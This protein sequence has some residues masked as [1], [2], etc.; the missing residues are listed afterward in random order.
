MAHGAVGDIE[1]VWGYGA[2]RWSVDQADRYLDELADA[3][4][5]IA[6][7]PKMYRERLEFVPPVRISPHGSHLIVYTELNGE[8]AIL[9][10][11]GGRQDWRAILKAMD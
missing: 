3:F 8:V 10:V 5:L 2:Q 11:L 7:S 1:E 9:R 4:D 6:R